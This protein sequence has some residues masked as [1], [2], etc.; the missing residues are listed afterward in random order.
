MNGV[1]SYLGTTR[2]PHSSFMLID[3]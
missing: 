1:F 2:K 3:K